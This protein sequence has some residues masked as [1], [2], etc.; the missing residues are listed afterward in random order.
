M[1]KQKKIAVVGAGGDIGSLISQILGRDYSHRRELHNEYDVTLVLHT[2]TAS[3]LPPLEAE[4]WHGSGARPAVK[5][6]ISDS[7]QDWDTIRGSDVVAF[8]AGGT[9][10]LSQQREAVLPGNAD[11]AA[12][13]GI[14]IGE[15]YQRD[16][17][18]PPLV[19]NVVNPLDS[20]LEI[21]RRAASNIPSSYFVGM[22][23]LLDGARLVDELSEHFPEVDRRDIICPIIASHDPK[24]VWV[25][26]QTFIGEISLSEH[27]SG[28]RI[29][30]ETIDMIDKTVKDW[31]RHMIEIKH[32]SCTWSA[33]EH[34]ADMIWGYILQ[35][36]TPFT[37]SAKLP[38][39]L[40][41]IENLPEACSGVPVI[42]TPTGVEISNAWCPNESERAAF[43]TSLRDIDTLNRECGF[44]HLAKSENPKIRAVFDAKFTLRD[45][46]RELVLQ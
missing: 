11:T 28:G 29:K 23:G 43:M 22:S 15:N 9:R 42:W 31:G 18:R 17:G 20:V 6:I 26:S 8:A 4:V 40:W 13:V 27:I 37:A 19:L 2:N 3:K 7:W 41:G 16:G 30:L 32:K 10:S 38:S 36:Q 24:L 35:D 45:R 12:E 33:A 14:A 46:Q 25:K 39:G 21:L 5:T 44:A 1:R 34:M